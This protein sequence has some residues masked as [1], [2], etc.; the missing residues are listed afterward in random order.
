MRSQARNG[1]EQW[2]MQ[3]LSAPSGGHRRGADSFERHRQGVAAGA[4]EIGGRRSDTERRGEATNRRDDDQYAGFLY[5][6]TV[7]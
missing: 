6:V 2:Q 3:Q 4:N 7:G 5:N 1:G